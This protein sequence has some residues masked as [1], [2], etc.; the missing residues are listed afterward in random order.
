MRGLCMCV[1]SALCLVF[2]I[3]L[4][5][6]ITWRSMLGMSVGKS[7]RFSLTTLFFSLPQLIMLLWK[8]FSWIVSV[9]VHLLWLYVPPTSHHG[10]RKQLVA[11]IRLLNPH[12]ICK[13]P[14]IIYQWMHGHCGITG[15]ARDDEAA[16]SVYD[17]VHA[18]AVALSRIN[19]AKTNHWCASLYM[20][21]VELDRIQQH[22]SS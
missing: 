19:A 21:A 3:S 7:F 2:I 12:V 17:C 10:L 11:G 9:M 22:S 16:R 4:T 18:V 5:I 6:T 15:N 20:V 14:N 1:W 13:G 8:L